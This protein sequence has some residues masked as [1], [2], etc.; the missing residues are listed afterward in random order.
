MQSLW[1]LFATF[2]FSLMSVCVKFASESYSTV[3]IVMYRSLV[4]VIVI[5]AMMVLRR[6]SFKT[7]FPLAHLW[8]GAVGATA[9]GLW[10]L[11]MANLPLGTAMTLNYMSPIWI[12]AIMFGIGWWHGKAQFE[13][14]LVLAVLASF[15]GVALLLRPAIHADQLIWGVYGLISG[16][17]ASLAYLQVRHLGILG[18]P[19]DRIVFYFCV[20][21][22][23]GGAIACVIRAHLPESDGVIWHAH[24]L[25]GFL[26]LAGIGVAAAI[27]QI[28]MTRAYH[29]GKTLV[30]ANL[31]YTGIVFSS[32]WGILFWDD[33][34]GWM[35]WF[36]MCIII[37]SGV[38]ATFFDVRHKARLTEEVY[39]KAKSIV[40]EAK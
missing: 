5:G 39:V 20:T 17:L 8:R 34:L 18:E 37:A 31:Q 26:L 30:T 10:F 29:L 27:G 14:R 22:T 35:G 11:S 3:E 4:G 40:E 24:D 33:K 36:G 21:G 7:R 9:F 23:I 2:T 15:T 12:A 38:T 19:E 32:V 13:W 6:K 1:M 28:A 25:K 16:M